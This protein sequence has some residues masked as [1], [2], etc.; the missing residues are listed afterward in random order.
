MMGMAKIT[1]KFDIR[2]IAVSKSLT[3]LCEG[4]SRRCKVIDDYGAVVEGEY[5]PLYDESLKT[6]PLCKVINCEGKIPNDIGYVL[7]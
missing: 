6:V 2:C 1:T 7:Y 5:C 4:M 3:D